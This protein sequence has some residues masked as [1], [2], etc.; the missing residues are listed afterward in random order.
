MRFV[1]TFILHLF[2]DTDT[3]NHLCGNL[4]PLTDQKLSSFRNKTELLGLLEKSAAAEVEI[5][6][7]AEKNQTRSES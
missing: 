3:P 6:Q 2:I 1:K 4:Q 5:T 7:R